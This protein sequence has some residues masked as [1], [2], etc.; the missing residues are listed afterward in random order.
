MQSSPEKL[1]FNLRSLLF[2]ED[3]SPSWGG[4]NQ[5]SSNPRPWTKRTKRSALGKKDPQFPSAFILSFNV[6]SLRGTYHS[7]LKPWVPYSCPGQ[8]RACLVFPMLVGGH[9]EVNSHLPGMGE[10]P[11]TVTWPSL[12]GLAPP[13][14][15]LWNLVVEASPQGVHHKSHA[16]SVLSDILFSLPFIS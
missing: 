7:I 14:Q 11:L 13:T 16:S 12:K 8:P 2:P 15:S 1:S 10:M 5:Q 4:G 3:L 6:H 9:R